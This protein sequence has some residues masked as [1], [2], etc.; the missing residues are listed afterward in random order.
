MKTQDY[1]KKKSE[2]S[3][4]VMIFP[5]NLFHMCFCS[6]QFY[7]L[8]E[9]TLLKR[10]FLTPS[11]FLICSNFRVD[12]AL[13]NAF[14]SEPGMAPCYGEMV[15]LGRPFMLVFSYQ[16]TYSITC[17]GLGKFELKDTEM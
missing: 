12:K 17:L 16:A 7:I 5:T 14:I 3:S 8:C 9:H 10:R 2:D 11:S 15:Q 1:Q 4:L 6:F 13:R